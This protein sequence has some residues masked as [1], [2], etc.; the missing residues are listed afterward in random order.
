MNIQIY[1]YS[2]DRAAEIADLFHSAVHAI[3]PALYSPAEQ[4]AW[5]PTP[6]DY[7]FWEARL[8]M[9]KPL[10]AIHDQCVAGFI[11]L[12][13]SG[14]IDCFY[15]HPDFQRQGVGG[16]LYKALEQQAQQR[17]IKLLFVEA[18]LLV[19][20]FFLQR[21]FQVISQNRLERNGE[22]LINFSMEKRLC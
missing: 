3:N 5:A 8:A 18:S 2:T 7:A 4:E 15:V 14:H 1:P 12:E 6:V 22:V 9:K 20:D 11:E 13:H 19:K 16:L 17:A 10:V 21:G